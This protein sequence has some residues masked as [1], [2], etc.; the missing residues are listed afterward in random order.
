M[1]N[2]ELF[3]LVDEVVKIIEDIRKKAAPRMNLLDLTG[4]SHLEVKNSNILAFLLDPQASHKMPK[5]S[6]LFLRHLKSKLPDSIKGTALRR[7]RREQFTG[8]RFIDL[9]L[10]TDHGEYIIIENKVGAGD[11]NEQLKDYIEWVHN[12][13]KK[14]PVAIY[15]TPSGSIPG[16]HS[17]QKKMRE[18]MENDGRFLCLSYQDD[19]IAWLDDVL[20]IIADGTD[21]EL[22]RSAIIQYIDAVNGFC[23]QREE[24]VMEQARII[25]YLNGNY[26]LIG[27]SSE[28]MKELQSV[29]N[30][31]QAAVDRITIMQF[32][33]ELYELFKQVGK[34]KV[35]LT[36]NQDRES[37]AGVW[38]EDCKKAA[39]NLGVELALEEVDQSSHFGI[40][41]EFSGTTR[42]TSV[43]FGI[44]AHGKNT[45]PNDLRISIPMRE[46][47]DI[48]TVSNSSNS[49]WCRRTTVG[50]WFNRALF[51]YRDGVHWQDE[52][53]SLA[54]HV[55]KNWFLINTE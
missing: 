28:R 12:T 47:E 10:E 16:D 19:I 34:Y 3:E 1:N 48:G 6:S 55:I 27:E 50:S 21:N 7:V 41:I 43:Y 11:L 39:G 17:L 4:V 20:S 2:D 9:F 8:G 52:H 13:F 36:L 53:G 5:I 18:S 51:R 24:D 22:L 46:L 25:E 44:M 26:N 38:L 49:W 54:S 42:D 29:A 23:G 33:I 15:L 35:Y 30:G 31:F 40:G 14:D 37:D 45:H 32:L